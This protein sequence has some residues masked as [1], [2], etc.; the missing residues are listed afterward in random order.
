MSLERVE[1]KIH[2][3]MLRAAN[4]LARQRDVTVGQ[5]VRDL[6]SREIG[7]ASAAKPPVRADERLVAPLRARLAHDLAEA[8]GWADL[9]ARLTSKGYV[10]RAAGGGLAL[11]DWPADRRICK[12]SE[13]GF[14]YARLMRRFGAPFPGHS[15]TWLEK[16][17]LNQTQSGTPKGAPDDNLTEPF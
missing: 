14:S 2:P 4:R 15:H 6:L 9:Q 1:M 10:L 5:L 12:A 3:D 7:R 17:H 8:E 13:L 16:Q 11:H